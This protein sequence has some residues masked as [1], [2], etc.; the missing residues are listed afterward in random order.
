MVRQRFIY[1]GIA[2]VFLW[3]GEAQ[4]QQDLSLR[5]SLDALEP[6]GSAPEPDTDAPVV[7]AAQ[8]TA[9]EV[10]PLIEPP[11]PPRKRRVDADDEYEALGIVAG[12]LIVFPVLRAGIVA[13]DNPDLDSSD[14]K[15][16]IGA[17][18]R[19]SL[20]VTSD[21]IRHELIFEGAGDLIYYDERSE[22]DS[23]D[24]DARARL[25]LDVLRSTTLALEADYSRTEESGADSEVPD[26]AIGNRVDQSFGGDAALTHHYGRLSA[27]L[28]AGAQAQYYSDVKLAGG[29][30]E[31]NGDREYVEPETVLRVGYETSPAIQPFVEV[32]YAPRIHF[33]NRDRNGFER[34]SDGYRA[35][36]GLAFE[37]SPLWSGELAAVYLLRDYEDSRLETI[38]AFGLI[39]RIIWRPTELTTLELKLDT[40]LNETA[41]AG[42]SGSRVYEGRL[43]V[44]HNLRDNLTLTGGTGLAHEDFQGT[45]ETNLKLRAAAG[46]E[47]RMN[48]SLAWTLDYDFVYNDSNLP[49]SDYY[50]NRVTAGIEVRR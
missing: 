26:T 50:E 32:A 1:C 13:S 48:R 34:S 17:R 11:P 14:R 9:L 7:T 28:K 27:T 23:I 15:G 36:A 37:P 41:D 4:A 18:L 8:P 22:N 44:S 10:N 35:A 19:P 39:G 47:W 21:W 30:R 42:S 5:S 20:R 40:S 38:D 25:R 31:R 12:G 45:D 3:S 33:E 24:A 29:G 2:A 49:D 16:D 43:G 46:I 6:G